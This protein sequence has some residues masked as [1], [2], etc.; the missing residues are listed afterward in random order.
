[1]SPFASATVGL[2]ACNDTQ[3]IQ[4]FS[5]CPAS[6]RSPRDVFNNQCRVWQPAIKLSP[7]IAKRVNKE[8]CDDNWKARNLRGKRLCRLFFSPPYE[9]PGLSSYSISRS[10]PVQFCFLPSFSGFSLWFISTTPL[11][12][13]VIMV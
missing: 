5:P 9:I 10:C 11:G 4:L 7:S 8:S 12:Q 13:D 3:Q 2:L 1:M 6:V